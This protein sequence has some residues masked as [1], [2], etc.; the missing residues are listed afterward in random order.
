MKKMII[1]VLSI[2]FITNVLFPQENEKNGQNS[3]KHAKVYLLLGEVLKVEN[4]TMTDSLMH[5]RHGSAYELRTLAL[6][7]V[8]YIQVPTKYYLPLG[9]LLGSAFAFAVCEVINSAGDVTTHSTYTT[10]YSYDENGYQS[11][12]TS[13]PQ[14]EVEKT[15]STGKILLITA[16][17]ALVCGLIGY[18]IHGGWQTIY[19]GAKTGQVTLGLSL[20]CNSTATPC[21]GLQLLF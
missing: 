2:L 15:L 16:G 20:A 7:N 1:A 12:S 17:G 3:Y 21:L 9:V 6:A 4:L 18:S 19:S 8:D 11:S 5:F 14:T 10:T 13:E